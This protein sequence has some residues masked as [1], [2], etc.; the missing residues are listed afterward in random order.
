MNDG[1][2]ALTWITPFKKPID[3]PAEIER[4]TKLI[5]K[6][7]K[8]LAVVRGRLASESFVANAPAAVVAGDRERLT[9]LERTVAGL[10]AQLERV[11]GLDGPAAS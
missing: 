8:D 9:D 11:R 5:G 3:A 2:R 10:N 7:Q 6:A 1:I 4:L